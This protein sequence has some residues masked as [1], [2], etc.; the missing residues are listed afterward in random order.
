M[1]EDPIRRDF[2]VGGFE[3]CLS[4]QRP[5]Q[6]NFL[7]KD[8]AK[9]FGDVNQARYDLD[10]VV[11]LAKEGMEF[12][13]RRRPRNFEQ[14]L[15]LRLHGTGAVCSMGKPTQS[16]SATPKSH[17]LHLSDSLRFESVLR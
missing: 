11:R 6:R 9:G 1:R 8:V 2:L 5:E 4:L 13:S 7:R 17:F 14:G 16:N 15:E 12:L 10:V 3:L